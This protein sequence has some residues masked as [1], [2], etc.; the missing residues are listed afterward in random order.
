MSDSSGKRGNAGNEIKRVEIVTGQDESGSIV[1]VDNVHHEVHAGHMYVAYFYNAALADDGYIDIAIDPQSYADMHM[2]WGSAVGG[3]KLVTLYEDPDLSNNGTELTQRNLNRT[4]VD[5]PGTAIYHTPTIS[6]PGTMIF[7]N[8]GPGGTGGQTP[9]SVLRR[10]T[11][12]I[13]DKDKLY[14]LRVQNIAGTVQP[15]SV[16]AQYYTE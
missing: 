8:F 3:D 11:E 6:D 15:A 14:L 1:Q 7:Q 2:T 5:N 4:I 12:F 13:L 9:G 16:V 10:D